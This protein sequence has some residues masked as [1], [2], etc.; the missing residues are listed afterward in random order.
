M[1]LAPFSYFCTCWKVRPSA[2]PSFPWLIASILRRM[3]TRLPTCL[4]MGFGALISDTTPTIK[5]REWNKIEEVQ[6]KARVGYGEQ[7]SALYFPAP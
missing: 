1:R 4:S 6:E 2:S 3:R 5:R 7:Q